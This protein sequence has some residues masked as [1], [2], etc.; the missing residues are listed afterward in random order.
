MSCLENGTKRISFAK[1][2]TQGYLD[3]LTIWTRITHKKNIK[4]ETFIKKYQQLSL[5]DKKI[6]KGLY[7]NILQQQVDIV[8]IQGNLNLKKING[9]ID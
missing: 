2:K 8:S 1:Q 4:K 9:L 5:D 6:L 7:D 3:M